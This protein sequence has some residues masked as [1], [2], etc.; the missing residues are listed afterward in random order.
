M[1]GDPLPPRDPQEPLELV[2]LGLR[3]D[4]DRGWVE[5]RRRLDPRWDAH[6]LAEHL[7][8]YLLG[9]NHDIAAGL[10]NAG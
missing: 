9:L 5:V 8:A 10:L 1:P 3:W 2:V 6:V 4:D 7:T